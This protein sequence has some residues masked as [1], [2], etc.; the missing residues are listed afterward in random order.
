MSSIR[1]DLTLPDHLVRFK[2]ELEN[3]QAKRLDLPLINQLS[4]R[5]K[6]KISLLPAPSK[7]EKEQIEQFLDSSK[8]VPM[9]TV[10]DT[11]MKSQDKARKVA[12]K[13][14]VPEDWEVKARIVHEQ[15]LEAGR[16]KR[17]VGREKLIPLDVTA[18]AYY[19]NLAVTREKAAKKHDKFVELD[20]KVSMAHLRGANSNSAEG[21]RTD[22]S[23]S[24]SVASD[25]RRTDSL[26]SLQS[27]PGSLNVT[28]K[29]GSPTASAG[30]SPTH[31][32]SFQAGHPVGSSGRALLAAYPFQTGLVELLKQSDTDADR[33]S[34]AGGKRQPSSQSQSRTNS[35]S[36]GPRP[37]AAA[38]EATRTMHSN[39]ASSL[40]IY[41]Q[42]IPYLDRQRINTAS[43]KVDVLG[44]LLKQ[45]KVTEAGPTPNP[46]P[47][48]GDQRLRTPDRPKSVSERQQE[49]YMSKSLDFSRRPIAAV[50]TAPL[51]EVYQ[52]V[53]KESVD[54]AENAY[55]AYLAG[56]KQLER[57]EARRLQREITD[58]AHL[59]ALKT[60]LYDEIGVDLD[61]KFTKARLCGKQVKTLVYYYNLSRM[62]NGFALLS[63]QTAR[64]TRARY[65]H[66][67]ATVQRAGRG[68]L[69]RAAVRIIRYNL[70]VQQ[71]ELAAIAAAQAAKELAAGIALYLMLRRNSIK[72]RRELLRLRNA[73]ALKIQT[74]VRGNMGRERAQLRRE[75]LAWLSYNATRIQTMSRATLARRLVRLMR[76]LEFVRQ[77][78]A[79]I[80]EL[81]EERRRALMEDG[82]S[83]CIARG[84]VASV[85]RKRIASMLYWNHIEKAMHIQWAVRGHLARKR[86]RVMMRKKRESDI[87]QWSGAIVI[88][89]YARRYIV[90]ETVVKQ[91][92]RDKIE[93]KAQRLREKEQL[94]RS[95][96][97]M[98]A[99]AADE[100]K[101]R[102]PTV[103]PTLF[104][105]YYLVKKKRATLIQAVW[106]GHHVRKRCFMLRC[107]AHCRRVGAHDRMLFDAA[108][109]IQ[110]IARGHTYRVNKAKKMAIQVAIMMQCIF[111]MKRAKKRVRDMG[112][113]AVAGD[114]ISRRL[115][116]AFR[117]WKAKDMFRRIVK[118]MPHARR[119]QCWVRKYIL[120]R[121][122]LRKRRDFLRTRAEEQLVGK[123][124]FIKVQAQ[125]QLKVLKESFDRDIGTRGTTFGREECW[126][127]GPLQALYL[128]ILGSKARA[129]MIAINANRVEGKQCVK[130]FNRVP[131]LARDSRAP[132]RAHSRGGGG[133]RGGHRGGPTSAS[134][135]EDDEFAR[136]STT[137]ALL[138]NALLSAI[139]LNIVPMPAGCKSLSAADI[140]IGFAAVKD[141]IGGNTICFAEFL[142][143]LN[144]LGKIHFNNEKIKLPEE[145]LSPLPTLTRDGSRKPGALVKQQSIVKK[146]TKM[147]AKIMD[148]VRRSF[149]VRGL[150]LQTA[151]TDAFWEEASA[152]PKDVPPPTQPQGYGKRKA[153]IVPARLINSHLPPPTMDNY[154]FALA[155]KVYLGLSDIPHLYKVY[156]YVEVE[157]LYVFGVLAG[158][159]QRLYREFRRQ[160]MMSKLK[161]LKAARAKEVLQA[162][163]LEL[164]QSLVRRFNHRNQLAHIAQGFLIKYIPFNGDAAYYYNP[165]T[166][167]SNYKKPKVL[168]HFECL[169]VPLPAPGLE[170][171]ITCGNCKEVATLNCRGCDE[172]MCKNCFESLHCKGKRKDHEYTRIP[173]CSY[174]RFQM[175]T[176]ECLTCTLNKPDKN[177]AQRYMVGDRGTYCDTCFT[178]FHDATE[179]HESMKQYTRA[180]LGLTGGSNGSGNPNHKVPGS[181]TAG[182]ANGITSNP[183]VIRDAYLI[184]QLIKRPLLTAHTYDPMVQVCEEC[185]WRS[186]LWRCNTCDQVYCNTCLIGL[187]SIGG[188]FSKHK[189]EILPY[190][191]PGMHQRFERDAMSQRLQKRIDRVARQYAKQRQ[192]LRMQMTVK[193][194]TWWRMIREGYAGRREIVIRR[195][196][197]RRAYKA[198][199][200]ETQRV[201]SK[202]LYKVRDFFGLAPVL[203][204]DSRE[205]ASLKDISMLRRE[206]AYGYIYEN[207][208]DWGWYVGSDV[209]P[210]RKGVPK[211]GFDV[212][213]VEE[214]KEQANLGGFRLPGRV[215]PEYNTNVFATVLDL[216]AI[217]AEKS[218]VRIGP[219]YFQLISVEPH[220]ITVN[221]RWRFK[222]SAP[223]NEGSVNGYED[224]ASLSS[225]SQQ[226]EE[227]RYPDGGL[228]MYRMPY[229]NSERGGLYHRMKFKSFDFFVGNYL[230]VSALDSYAWG[231]RKMANFGY[232]MAKVAK[233]DGQ[234]KDYR[235][236]CTWAKKYDENI[237]WAESFGVEVPNV[238]G[239]Q[240]AEEFADELAAPP[241][242]LTEEDMYEKPAEEEMRR[243]GEYW[244]APPEF[245]AN[246][247][248]EYAQLTREE[249][250]SK[251][252]EWELQI[253]PMSELPMYI[254][255]ASK[256][257]MYDIPAPVKAKN[258]YEEEMARNKAQFAEAQAR[259]DAL[260]KKNDPKKKRKM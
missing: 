223:R 147:S 258:L 151:Y 59:G 152:V 234:R 230:V 159:I 69:G 60:S 128:S 260:N 133:S 61:I 52:P 158:R 103:R 215:I 46:A 256:Q 183:V 212:G 80:Q 85:I 179:H 178:Y 28:F 210:R 34:A 92:A 166:R 229:Q 181:S 107:L 233:K 119:V 253:D 226:P 255:A 93:H 163:R 182:G 197:L 150:L 66:A 43:A 146:L 126:G 245:I 5:T 68:M 95:R 111:R 18:T 140:E 196:R 88:Q 94:L 218:I 86:F 224:E 26:S 202:L 249:L 91:A 231:N 57:A 89:K 2:E 105:F 39:S 145:G 214:L 235:S 106:R 219:C 113:K 137:D 35:R 27:R 82:A 246:Q 3:M 8:N 136:P 10:Y 162:S 104:P 244:M 22:G 37:P 134:G 32:P 100:R 192:V 157:S 21:P 55:S 131:R 36:R 13:F 48:A 135:D 15:K 99:Q 112:M 232:K 81:Q 56:S 41:Q 19:D 9:T 77:W 221:R 149:P 31:A 70:A 252:E 239:V 148:H 211:T 180:T 127:F 75:Y 250:I 238:E 201:R 49:L 30:G 76:K 205:E 188:P 222:K 195:R 228:I 243:V 101:F 168:R 241:P 247:D 154:G 259:I 185:T 4:P 98:T 184:R 73:A 129:D 87:R 116:E 72:V 257:M 6:K 186:A 138:E 114:V 160:T 63:V 124:R 208:D 200:L 209:L 45:R 172:S 189:A 173:Q 206:R 153:A 144:L 14:Q 42:Q 115:G 33:T 54:A 155:I 102:F 143:L 40:A 237:A 142:Q 117:S 207:V 240:T 217:V 17:I 242:E 156:N 187:H 44:R 83:R 29:Q 58:H 118:I 7:L 220:Q 132:G 203:P 161:G 190:Y 1:D 198:H 84:Y 165:S 90:E 213:Y 254:H 67:V 51:V 53:L 191:T 227:E 16:E 125:Y 199:K 225:L 193:L 108:T 120:G 64:A 164:A 251:A 65:N 71:A 174:C 236:W 20:K 97:Q 74:R 12:Q 50:P 47:V 109:T 121:N 38:S 194:Q 248:E 171:I 204:T 24:V 96:M 123:R 122:L 170:N 62:Q 167:K 23:G 25:L 78:M 176:K 11:L 141:P 177:S 175:A 139:Q 169:E 79:N 130:F 216:T 110:R